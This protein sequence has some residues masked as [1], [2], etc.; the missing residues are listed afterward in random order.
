[1]AKGSR[2]NLERLLRSAW[3]RQT[4]LLAKGIFS[5]TEMPAKRELE[6]V[7]SDSPRNEQLSTT[8]KSKRRQ[9]AVDAFGILGWGVLV[10]TQMNLPD[11]NYWLVSVA[12][13]FFLWCLWVLI[14]DSW[15]TRNEKR[16]KQIMALILLTSVA[17]M[18]ANI[19]Y[20]I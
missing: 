7:R 6:D 14:D 1:M 13:L 20:R 19:S 18:G 17:G 10:W 9:L 8:N 12:F 5:N 2:T 11:Q 16:K 15:K 3:E 4:I